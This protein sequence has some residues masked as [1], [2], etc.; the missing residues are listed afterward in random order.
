MTHRNPTLADCIRW[1]DQLGEGATIWDSDL[2]F[3]LRIRTA[4]E[5]LVDEIEAANAAHPRLPE[6]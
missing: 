5:S 4:L 2:K 3:I 6:T 1:L